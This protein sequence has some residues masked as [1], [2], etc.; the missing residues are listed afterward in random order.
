M[1]VLRSFIE[2]LSRGKTF[3]KYIIVNGIKTPL[4]VTPDAQLKFLKIWDNKFDI[5]LIRIAERCLKPE[6]NVWDIG[7]NVGVFTFSAAVV[8]NKGYV[9]SV[10]ADIWLASIIQ[11][12]TKLKGNRNK[13]IRVLPA[14]ISEFNSVQSFL[15]AKRG[16]ASN[17]LE[18]AY[19]SSQAGGVREKLYVPTLT[20][21]NLSNFFPKPDFIKIDIEGAE[22]LALNGGNKVITSI[23][24]VFYIEVGK[25]T[26]NE[27][28]RIFTKESYRL[29]DGVTFN[30]INICAYNTLFV[31]D[32]KCNNNFFLQT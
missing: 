23:R 28:Q 25:H 15:I 2:R 17:A 3:K 4:F 26:S 20:L 18:I 13:D 27:I 5:D 6:S 30:P 1:S 16:R 19:G 7:A 9:L 12:S 8:A 24:P 21:D 14:A 22:L 32:E 10:E 11:K 29:F 31:P